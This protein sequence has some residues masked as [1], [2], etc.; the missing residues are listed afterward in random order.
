M[1]LVNVK[2]IFLHITLMP[3]IAYFMTLIWAS[4]FGDTF[5]IEK[6]NMFTEWL[7]CMQIYVILLL[8][9]K[10]KPRRVKDDD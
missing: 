6:N 8:I 1:G 3:F 2:L 10:L 5:Y 9:R 7:I 4:G